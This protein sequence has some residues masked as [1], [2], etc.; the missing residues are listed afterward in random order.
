MRW[1][2]RL[3]KTPT[4]GVVLDPFLG[5]CTTLLACELEGRQGIGIEQDRESFEIAVRRLEEARN[6]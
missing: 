1:L 2:V 3:T 6:A 4:G 5:S